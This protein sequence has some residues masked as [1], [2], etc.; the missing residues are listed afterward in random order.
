[1]ES[2]RVGDH[3]R[4]EEEEVGVLDPAARARRQGANGVGH[5]AVVRPQQAVDE[6]DQGEDDGTRDARGSQ[7]DDHRAPFQS[8]GGSY[9]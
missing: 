1:M 8:V 7:C 2:Y 9:P 4:S 5:E 3:E 6:G